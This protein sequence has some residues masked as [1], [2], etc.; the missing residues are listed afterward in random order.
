MNA[1]PRWFFLWLG[2]TAVLA[3][4]LTAPTLRAQD[5]THNVPMVSGAKA[6]IRLTV[7]G[8]RA[9]QRGFLTMKARIANRLP[10]EA[11]WEFSLTSAPSFFRGGMGQELRSTH[12]LTVP[13]ETTREFFVFVP[14]VT[15]DTGSGGNSL[16]GEVSGPEVA[17]GTIYLNLG[18]G[19]GNVLGPMAMGPGLIAPWRTVVE[20]HVGTRR[21]ATRAS[22]GV[23]AAAPMGMAPPAIIDQA[24]GRVS[25]LDPATLPADW[26]VWS[27]FNVVMLQT[28][29]WERLDA[30][31][32]EALQAAVVFGL[33][34][35]LVPPDQR[36]EMEKKALGT[37]HIITL[38]GP[39]DPTRL[40]TL[41][42]LDLFDRNG[43]GRALAPLVN[44]G[45]W[46]IP[47][48]EWEVPVGRGWLT[49]FVI[50]F[51]LL[52]GPVNVFFFAK[53]GRRHRLFF[54]VPAI[55]LAAAAALMA[56]IM[57]K[58]GFGGE[59]SR[60]AVVVLM[61]ERNQAAVFQKQVSR[62]GLLG[63]R[64]FAL[65][66][67]VLM[68]RGAE[69]T[70]ANASVMVREGEMAS[71]DWFAS[72]VIQTHELTRLWPT[73]ER[74]E[75]L[76]PVAGAPADAAP[77]VQSTVGTVLRDFGYRDQGG[78]YW[79]AAELPPGVKTTLRPAEGAQVDVAPFRR[80]SWTPGRFFARA[81]E[82]GQPALIPTLT[83][84]AWRD[85]IT[86]YT[87]E[88]APRS[89]P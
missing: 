53:A 42:A 75:L 79:V 86:I 84:L 1:R 11:T 38:D 33:R 14:V 77:V 35:V 59:G 71:G 46:A 3:A 9:A 34:L 66:A 87:G 18:Y 6:D 30:A 61:P 12:R 28:D 55:S 20:A 85:D 41:R 16:R 5:A 72:R 57:V 47:S 58:D 43:G 52:I 51:G 37:S 73:R 25:S 62:T 32:K 2:L 81:T 56:M 65:P 89:A 78:R 40:N 67:D 54:T 80:S 48:R 23:R 21:P 44:E 60:R 76:P 68:E 69:G 82:P 36:D 64:S 63:G 88:L 45:F 10:E 22:G 7:P 17:T 74:I 8:G 39:L 24:M 26:R 4:G 13:A 49:A 27:P 83:S 15:F 50:G 19:W 29:T 31:R 70:A